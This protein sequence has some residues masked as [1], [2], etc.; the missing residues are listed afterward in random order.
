MTRYLNRRPNRARDPY[1]PD[2]LFSPAISILLLVLTAAGAW[3]FAIYAIL[4][5]FRAV[6]AAVGHAS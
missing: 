2:R 6:A 5:L 4:L 3:A 1:D